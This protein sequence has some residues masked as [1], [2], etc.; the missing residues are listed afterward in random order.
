MVSIDPVE[1]RGFELAGT[2]RNQPVLRRSGADGLRKACAHP[3]GIFHQIVK[4]RINTDESI[5]KVRQGVENFG[6]VSLLQI[7]QLVKD[8]K[9]VV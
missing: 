2:D 1:H 8:R 6:N 9:S 3:M 7:G 5:E 4:D